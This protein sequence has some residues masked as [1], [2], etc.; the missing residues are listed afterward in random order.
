MKIKW[1]KTNLFFFLNLRRNRQQPPPFRRC[2]AYLYVYF[3]VQGIDGKPF[4]GSLF[5][6]LFQ[7][8]T[9]VICDALGRSRL[10]KRTKNR[11]SRLIKH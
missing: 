9:R 3:E 6:S 2:F 11:K 8:R 7:V 10:T 4:P 1:M 5:I